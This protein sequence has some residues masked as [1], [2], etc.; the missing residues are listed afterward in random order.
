MAVKASKFDT[1]RIYSNAQFEALP[2][3]DQLYELVE[4]KIVEKVMPGDN[5]GR[6][7]EN[8][9]DAILLFDPAKKLGR[10]WRDTNFEFGPGML[11]IPDLG[12]IAASRVPPVTKASVKAEPDLVLEVWSPRELN[13]RNR[14][15]EALDKVRRYQTGGVRIVWVVKPS[16]QTVE[17]YHPDQPESVYVLK[18]DMELDGEDVLPGF[19]MRVADLFV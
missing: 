11:L 18:S 7:V 17:V 9:A 6:I 8:L 12:F 1:E 19:K 3:F 10:K 5:R 2:Q 14:Q 4:G 16:N 13:S 15:A